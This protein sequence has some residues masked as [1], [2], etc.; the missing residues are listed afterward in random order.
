[1]TAP[2][3]QRQCCLRCRPT[4]AC[5]FRIA[6]LSRSIVF[7]Q[8]AASLHSRRRNPA[9]TSHS[10]LAHLVSRLG[11]QLGSRQI[12]LIVVLLRPLPLLLPFSAINNLQFFFNLSTLLA[13]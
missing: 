9:M 1:M 3:S 11:R 12:L 4:A 6:T 5:P 13:L 2:L 10:P 7:R 8:L